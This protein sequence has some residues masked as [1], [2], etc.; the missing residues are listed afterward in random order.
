M[1]TYTQPVVT[2]Q[3]A[4][5]SLGETVCVVSAGPWFS[6]VTGAAFSDAVIESCEGGARDLLLDLTGVRAVDAAGTATLG[7]LAEQF[8]VPGCELAVGAPPPARGAGPALPP[9]RA[10]SSA[11]GCRRCR[12]TSTFRAPSRSKKRSP[13]CCGAP[14]SESS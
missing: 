8:D 2:T 13:V 3:V 12:S 10:C 7:A 11:A 1:A 14:S 5:R 6:A 4:A 9:P